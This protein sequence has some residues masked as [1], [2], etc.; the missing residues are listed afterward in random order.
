[1]GCFAAVDIFGIYFLQKG[2]DNGAVSSHQYGGFG[3][4][5]F[6]AVSLDVSHFGHVVLP[7]IKYMLYTC[8]G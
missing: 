7:R 5:I 2:A 4:I 1:M 6:R 8:I 3:W